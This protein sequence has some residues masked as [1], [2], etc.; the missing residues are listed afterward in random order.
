[1]SIAMNTDVPPHIEFVPQRCRMVNDLFQSIEVVVLIIG[2]ISE[3]IRLRGQIRHQVVAEIRR[4][5]QWI[6]NDGFSSGRL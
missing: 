4:V 2:N 1:M 6:G 3:R 5:I